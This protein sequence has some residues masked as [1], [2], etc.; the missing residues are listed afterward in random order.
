MRRLKLIFNPVADRGHA[1]Q[2]ADELQQIVDA[3]VTE[4]RENR[5][6]VE[7]VWART[8]YKGHAVELARDAAAEGFDVVTAIGGDGTVHEVVNGLMATDEAQRPLLGV[9]PFG[10]G[11]DFAHNVGLP[12]DPHEATRCLLG[13]ATRPVDIGTIK[14]GSGRCEYWTNTVGI[15]FSGA[16]NMAARRYTRVRGFLVYLVA[17][18]ETIA[19]A[20]FSLKAQIKVDDSAAAE[21]E[22]AMIAFCNGPREGG[23]FF[24]GPGAA[25]DDGLITYVLM[26]NMSRASM[27]RFLPIVMNGKHLKHSRFFQRGEAKQIQLETNRTMAIHADGEVFGSWDA[28]IRELELKMLPAAV[29]VLVNC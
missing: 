2:S 11:N 8:E 24:V 5:H 22:V 12:S 25:M 16:V 23:G 19:S 4:A 17:V 27:L 29:R 1:A 21:H 28:G 14:D 10:S 26:R 6:P 9:I 3:E 7:V 20:P 13:E 18:F 15:G